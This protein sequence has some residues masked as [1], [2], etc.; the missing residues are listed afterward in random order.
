MHCEQWS[1][2]CTRYNIRKLLSTSSILVPW[3]LW[4]LWLLKKIQP[5][6]QVNNRMCEKKKEKKMTKT[7]RWF[8]K[9]TFCRQHAKWPRVPPLFLTV[10]K[11]IL[12]SVRATW[13]TMQTCLDYVNWAWCHL[14]RSGPSNDSIAGCVWVFE[15][16]SFCCCKRTRMNEIQLHVDNKMLHG[17]GISGS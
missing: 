15:V 6:S 4:V 12:P 8:L 1:P 5:E 9:A 17:H 16:Q 11:I 3:A 7:L 10:G 2:D 14:N 13:H